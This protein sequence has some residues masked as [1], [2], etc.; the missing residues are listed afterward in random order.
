MAKINFIK[1]EARGCGFKT[2][3][4]F[5]L[6][7]EGKGI[8]CGYLPIDLLEKPTKKVKSKKKKQVRYFNSSRGPT[9][10]KVGDLIPEGHVCKLPDN[11]S[12]EGGCQGCWVRNIDK[13][14]VGLLLWVGMSYYKTTDLFD[15]E[16]GRV[17]ISRKIPRQ[18]VKKIQVGKTPVFLAHK[19]GSNILDPDTMEV[20]KVRQIFRAFIPSRMEYVVKSAM[21]LLDKRTK[22]W[23]AYER[24]LNELEAQGVTLIHVEKI[25]TDKG[26]FNHN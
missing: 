23:K 5:Y 17:G 24:Y 21:L 19:E 25:G 1:E 3:D 8:L 13:E 2:E 9:W 18:L 16:A 10:A 26:L 22:A 7:C 4:S 6:R 15:K 20:I 14:E 11:P 12:I